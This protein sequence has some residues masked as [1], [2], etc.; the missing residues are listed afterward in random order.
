MTRPLMSPLVETTETEASPRSSEPS[1]RSCEPS[2]RF[3][4]QPPQ[5]SNPGSARN[6]RRRSNGVMKGRNRLAKSMTFVDSPR[7]GRLSSQPTSVS[8]DDVDL[9]ESDSEQNETE[10]TVDLEDKE[11]SVAPENSSQ[12][13]SKNGLLQ[14]RKL[15]FIPKKSSGLKDTKDVYSEETVTM[16]KREGNRLPSE[17][18]ENIKNIENSR[19]LLPKS[20]FKNQKTETKSFC[21][22]VIDKKSDIILPEK[23]DKKPINHVSSVHRNDEIRRT[24]CLFSPRS[25]NKNTS[26]KQNTRSSLQIERKVSRSPNSMELSDDSPGAGNKSLRQ[27]SRSSNSMETVD[28]SSVF[29]SDR[30]SK[31]I[32]PR[33]WNSRKAQKS[34]V[35]M[36][37]SFE[38]NFEVKRIDLRSSQE[39]T[40]TKSPMIVDS[41]SN[42]CS[43]LNDEFQSNK[44]EPVEHRH[45]SKTPVPMET[46]QFESHSSLIRKV[47]FNNLVEIH[48][49][50]DSKTSDILR[51]SINSAQRYKRLYLFKDKLENALNE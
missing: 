7:V 16:S 21:K 9:W 31:E 8:L 17:S 15:A 23:S 25:D 29:R 2:P 6:R 22:K 14:K 13:I 27:W 20:P 32:I 49:D 38:L 42:D 36:D 19:V 41:D 11:Q 40:R 48:G 24:Y 47:K 33:I 18:F 30:S 43:T 34:P 28:V 35:P 1:P 26:Y 3:S 51:D 12:E 46:E 37:S 5:H 4:S 39:R 50:H 44:S 10:T 45:V